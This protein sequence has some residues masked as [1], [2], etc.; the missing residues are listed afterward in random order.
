MRQP[1]ALMDRIKKKLSEMEKEGHIAKVTAEPT[2]WVN[3]IVTVVKQYKVRI[4]LD[5]KDLN[6]ATRREH[7]K[8]PTVEEIV[9]S[10]PDATVLSVLDAK[11]GLLQIKIYYESSL[12]TTFNTPIGR[13]RWFRLPFGI[14][15]ALE[16][17]QR[18]MDNML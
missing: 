2:D 8:I 6:R 11:S 15:S 12:L 7:Y 17:F 13:Y 10:I 9:A 16:M 1:H 5:P 3:S 14:K 18:I 4:C